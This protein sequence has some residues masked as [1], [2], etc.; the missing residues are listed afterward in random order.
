MVLIFSFF[1]WAKGFNEL[2]GY[3]VTLI[4]GQIVPQNSQLILSYSQIGPQHNQIV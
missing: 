1:V 3:P 2:Q 4:H